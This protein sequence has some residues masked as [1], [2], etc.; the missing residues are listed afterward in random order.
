M[1]VRFL[2]LYL[3]GKATVLNIDDSKIVSKKES[4][5]I[6]PN[7]VIPCEVEDLIVLRKESEEADIIIAQ[8]EEANKLVL[9]EIDQI[10]FELNLLASESQYKTESSQ[11]VVPPPMKSSPSKF[12]Y[13]HSFSLK[14]ETYRVMDIVPLQDMAVLSV[15][16]KPKQQYGLRK[17]NLYDPTQTEFI[18]NHN[19]PIKDIK[20][21]L[22]DKVLSTGLDK[23]LKITSLTSNQVV[24]S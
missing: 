23:T 16:N 1:R 4:R 24:Q 14:N 2:S 6:W 8:L 11:P 9:G 15:W 12:I 10:K 22:Q 3:D 13:Q 5:R 20:N 19:G 7:K 18:P 21:V 17:V